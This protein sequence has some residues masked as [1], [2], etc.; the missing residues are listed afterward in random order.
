MKD[1][2]SENGKILLEY[3]DGIISNEII[4]EIEFDLKEISIGFYKHDKSKIIF[5]SLEDYTNKIILFLSS[6]IIQAYALGLITNV[7]YDILKKLI[8]KIINDIKGKNITLRS[9]SKI[10]EKEVTFGLKIKISEDNLLDLRLSGEFS[11][12][13]QSKIIDQAFE[14][15]KNINQNIS[16]EIRSDYFAH[17]DIRK[18][19]WNLCNI[20]KELYKKYRAKT[21]KI[22]KANISKSVD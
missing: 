13:I 4:E 5:N 14:V 1:I 22:E 9:S 11:E 16:S 18:E 17:Y 7:T 12:E 20:Q 15:M 2:N 6:D 3:Y 21:E 19:R 8:L 10:E